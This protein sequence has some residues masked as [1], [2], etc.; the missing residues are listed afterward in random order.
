MTALTASRWTGDDLFQD[1]V[2]FIFAVSLVGRKSPAAPEIH[3]FIQ[4]ANKSGLHWFGCA[5]STLQRRC[6]FNLSIQASQNDKQ[7]QKTWQKKKQTFITVYI[8]GGLSHQWIKRKKKRKKKLDP[9]THQSASLLLMHFF[10]AYFAFPSLLM[11]GSVWPNSL[12]AMENTSVKAGT[13]TASEQI[14]FICN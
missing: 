5:I 3:Q 11:C 8:S 10:F 14:T 7:E 12:C 9:K 2:G 6:D 4:N 1:N 13:A